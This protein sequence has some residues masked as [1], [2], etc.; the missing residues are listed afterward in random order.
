M[1]PR[2]QQ[3]LSKLP[4]SRHVL[5]VFR[6]IGW[7]KN[8]SQPVGRAMA[9]GAAGIGFD[10]PILYGHAANCRVG[11]RR[12]HRFSARE[13]L[14]CAVPT[15]DPPEMVQFGLKPLVG[16]GARESLNAVGG[17]ASAFAHPTITVTILREQKKIGPCFGFGP[18]DRPHFLS[19]V[20]LT[21]RGMARRQGARPGSPGR[22]WHGL[23][24]GLGVTRHAPRLAARQR[25]IFGLRL[26]QRSGRTRSCLS[27]EG[28]SRGRPW[29]RLA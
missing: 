21:S 24:P 26:S 25:G 19:S 20:S 29:V 23:R 8:K 6:L 11:K 3:I 13:S 12:W 16:N 14:A 28:L 9:G 18:G 15:R 17:R 27:L 2:S 4:C 22:R 1:H 7:L 5:P 10:L